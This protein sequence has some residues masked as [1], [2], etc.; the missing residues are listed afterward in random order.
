MRTALKRTIVFVLARLPFAVW[1][2]A[3]RIVATIWP[4][5]RDA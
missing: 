1:P 4:G 3:S 2:I 5:F